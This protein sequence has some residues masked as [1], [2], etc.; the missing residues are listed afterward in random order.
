M[1]RSVLELAPLLFRY[2]PIM[3]AIWGLASFTLQSSFT[4]VHCQF[5]QFLLTPTDL[6]QSFLASRAIRRGPCGAA[7]P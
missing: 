3:L 2:G 7:G 4:H 5:L 1:P 6:Y